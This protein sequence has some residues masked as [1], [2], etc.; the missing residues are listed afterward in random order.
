MQHEYLFH[1]Y[2]FS[3]PTH[4]CNLCLRSSCWEDD[5][6]NVSSAQKSLIILVL[7][8]APVFPLIFTKTLVG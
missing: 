2:K 6:E 8:L 4:L 3:L 7:L 5:A 1:W